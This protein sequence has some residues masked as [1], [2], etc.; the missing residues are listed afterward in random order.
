MVQVKLQPTPEQ[1]AA[2]EATLAACNTAANAVSQTVFTTGVRKPYELQVLVYGELKASG[3]SAQ[4]AIR[5]IKK[6]ADAYKTLHALIRVGHLGKPGSRRR[7]KAES[8][9]ITF[10]PDAAQPFDERCLS[11]QLDARTISIWTSAGRLRGISFTGSPEQLQRLAAHRK[12]ESDLIRRDG[13]WFLMATCEVPTPPTAEPADW[14]GVDRGIVNLATTSNG[15]NYSGASLARYRRQSRPH[16][17]RSA[18][19]SDRLGAAQAETARQKGSAIRLADLPALWS[20]LALQP[21]NPRHLPLPV[22]RAR[23]PSRPHRRREHQTTCTNGVGIRQ[24]AQRTP[25]VTGRFHAAPACQPDRTASRKP[26][27]QPLGR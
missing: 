12:G 11:W 6:V 25:P 17:G 15:T 21:F 7:V 5:V 3:L 20:C 18:G 13:T 2:L 27:T 8:K 9:P 14:L 26:G 16:S 1:A 4:P 23:W 19:A 10:R 22:V 24:H